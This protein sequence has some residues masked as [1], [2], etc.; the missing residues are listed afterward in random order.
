MRVLWTSMYEFPAL[1]KKIGHK[2]NV[3]GGWVNASANA[4]L[5]DFPEL[6]LGVIIPSEVKSLEKDE[7]DDI[8]FYRVPCKSHIDYSFTLKQATL[9][10]V[11]DFKPDI[12]HVNGTEHVVGLALLDGV[13]DEV[14]IVSTIQGLAHVCKFYTDGGIKTEMKHFVTLRDLFGQ[15]SLRTQ[16]KLMRERGNLEEQI[17]RKLQFIIGRTTWDKSHVI[18]LNPSIN[19]YH[20]NES[21]RPTFFEHEW[22]YQRCNKHSILVSNGTSALKGVHQV[23]KA[24]P[25]IKLVY[26]DVKVNIVGDDFFSSKSF[27]ERLHVT[28]YQKY[29]F[30]LAKTLGVQKN[31]QFLG[32]LSEREMCQAFLDCNVYVLPSYIENSPNSLGEAQVLGVPA[33]SSYVGGV[34]SL[35]EEGKTGCMYRYEEYEM[36]AQL[37]IQFFKAKDCPELHHQERECGLTRHNPKVNAMRMYEIYLTIVEL[38]EKGNENI[39][40]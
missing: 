31:I 34:P 2:S 15:S 5:R 25:L 10:V 38:Y 7:I 40:M 26:P 39:N 12:I 3:F 4:L 30:Y 37:V 21:L 9:A 23:I 18:A 14:P 36:L 8:T 11:D 24:L 13:G 33:I 19:Y 6:K 17:I 16:A 29:L 20:C 27:K 1:S 22:D 28:G 35:I 32:M